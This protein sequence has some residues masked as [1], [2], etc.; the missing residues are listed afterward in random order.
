MK[1]VLVMVLALALTMASFAGCAK[2]ATENVAPEAPQTT[3][4]EAVG[5]KE[6]ENSEAEASN[7][8]EET[9]GVTKGG[10]LTVALLGNDAALLSPT[11]I[12][13]TSDWRIANAIYDTL[14]DQD[15]SG[16]LIPYL[17]ESWEEDEENLM[18][19]FHLRQDVLFHD[20]SQLTAEVAKWNLDYF[21][22]NGKILINSFDNVDSVEVIGEY[23]FVIHFKQYDST[24]IYALLRSGG[25]MTSKAAFD[26]YGID[27]LNQHPIGTG[28]MM[29]ESWEPG[30]KIHTVK[31]DDYWQ[32]EPNLDGVDFVVYADVSV[33][34][35]AM[36]DGSL[37]V[38]MNT[39]KD[40]ADYMAGEGYTVYYQEAVGTVL[41]VAMN[42]TNPED[43]L[44][45]VNVRKAVCHAIDN[46]AIAKLVLGE[47]GSP[48]NQ[49]AIA[50]SPCYSN[51]VTGYPYD[52]E[53]SKELLAAA[54]YPNGFDTTLRVS[55][56]NSTYCAMCEIIVTQLAEVGINVKMEQLDTAGLTAIISGWDTGM[57]FHG[58]QLTFG[59]PTALAT[60]FKQ[61]LSS[62]LGLT[63]FLHPDDIND[64]ILQG[65]GSSGAKSNECFREV[66]YKIF[67]EYCMLK[68]ICA[69]QPIVVT[70]PKVHD[71]GLYSI[72]LSMAT[73]GKAWKDA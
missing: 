37:D 8:P 66:N 71:T 2:E 25:Y 1:K 60:N 64:L 62:G 72:S 49:Y 19:T 34:Q 5:E 12:Y 21:M 32:G 65:V 28:P 67:E 59:S 9:T 27:Y 38:L 57:I 7:E 50:G 31:F 22:E 14:I 61:G 48:T 26:Q 40:L 20:G 15:A 47:A 52:P 4:T 24:F 11:G 68:A 6:E 16:N 42:C 41:T 58:N 53:K 54:G 63:S 44:Y 55:S 73:L 69:N 51:D 35:A 56:S 29:F 46:A 36:L 10:I 3:E 45:D 23:D 43:P 70:S 39:S 13:Q 30:V 33:A 17:A 18:I